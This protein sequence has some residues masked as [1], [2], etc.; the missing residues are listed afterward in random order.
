MSCLHCY[1]RRD[2]ESAHFDRFSESGSTKKEPQSHGK[3][4]WGGYLAF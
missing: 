1:V 2:G 4:D 3:N